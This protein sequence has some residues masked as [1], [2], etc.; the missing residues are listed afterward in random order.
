MTELE[1]LQQQALDKLRT[2]TIVSD[3][4]TKMV[5]TL[6]ATAYH[7][8]EKRAVDYVERHS[9]F[10]PDGFWRVDVNLLEAARTAQ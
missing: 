9:D 1:T 7:A 3:K 2:V 8:G 6:I 4:D 5:D 10:H